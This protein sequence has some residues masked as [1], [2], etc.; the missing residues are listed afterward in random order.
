[1][2]RPRDPAN[3]AAR[4]R[5]ERWRTRRKAA[6]RPEASIVDRAVAASV[7]VFLC[8]ALGSDPSSPQPSAQDIVIGSQRILLAAGYDKLQTNAEL[9]RR[10]TRRAD[11]TTLSMTTRVQ[12]GEE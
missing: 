12:S 2:P 7:A 6:G 4:A 11:L 1:M 3:E 5:T 9:K 10:L 8:K